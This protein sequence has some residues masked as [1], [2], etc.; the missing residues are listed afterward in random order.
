M[1]SRIAATSKGTAVGSRKSEIIQSAR[2]LLARNGTAGF[3]LREVAKDVGIKLASLQYHFPTRA[4]LVAAMLA[5]TVEAYMSE[6]EALP[7]A[8]GDD[9]E[10]AL[11]ASLRW[12]SGVEPMDEE[13]IQFEIHLWAMAL[14]DSSVSKSLSDYH[15]IYLGKIEELIANARPEI[16]R[17]EVQKRAIAIA[18]LQEGI[19]VLLSSRVNQLPQH[20]MLEAAYQASISIALK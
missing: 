15:R 7:G 8:A 14:N 18:S 16:S 13:E 20:E 2:S 19:L 3:S 17:S 9:P 5:N 12:L 1:W 10:E 4:A 11:T 6:L